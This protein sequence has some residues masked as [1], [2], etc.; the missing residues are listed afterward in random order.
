MMLLTV[1]IIFN[2]CMIYLVLLLFLATLDAR[3]G[4]VAVPEI[5]TVNF[6]NNNTLRHT[7]I[8]L[9]TIFHTLVS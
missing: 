9:T 1:V 2:V 5:A 6:Y 3:L 4:F 8:V 7:R